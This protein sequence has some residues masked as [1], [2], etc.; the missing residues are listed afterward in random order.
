V[1]KNTQVKKHSERKCSLR[2]SSEENHVQR[3]HAHVEEP[4]ATSWK[5]DESVYE[6]YGGTEDA[7]PNG[8]SVS[9]GIPNDSGIRNTPGTVMYDKEKKRVTFVP[10]DNFATNVNV[11]KE[12]MYE[13][14]TA[15]YTTISSQRND[16]LREDGH[17]NV[18]AAGN[19]V[20]DVEFQEHETAER[21]PRG[22]SQET[23]YG[24]EYEEAHRINPQS[25][26]DG[27]DFG[28]MEPNSHAVYTEEQNMGI[29][30]M[31]QQMP[32]PQAPVHVTAMQRQKNTGEWV[33]ERCG[34]RNLKKFCSACG[35]KNPAL[36]PVK[37]TTWVCMNCGEENPNESNFCE[38]CGE[39][40][41]EEKKNWVCG[42]CGIEN[43]WQ[44]K[45]CLECGEEKTSVS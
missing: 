36:K 17:S 38:E 25:A 6:T 8:L 19:P 42:A 24:Y 43:P 33:C 3:R 26:E 18:K 31:P 41:P 16:L 12:P 13:H 10:N 7:Q 22:E 32:Q 4:V 23:G 9:R 5:D 37:K 44:T 2:Q 28:E 29:P 39:K 15:G 11:I 30:E 35:T 14:H 34:T 21:Y 20:M 27:E 40:R 1:E 45:W